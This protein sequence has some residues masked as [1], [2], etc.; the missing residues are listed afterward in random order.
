VLGSV[1][2]FLAPVAFFL[3]VDTLYVAVEE[4]KLLEV[5]GED[6]ASYKK[7]VRRWV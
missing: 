4:R 1:T 6:Y 2:P 7:Q 3:L 5:F